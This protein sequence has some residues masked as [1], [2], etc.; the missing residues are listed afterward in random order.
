MQIFRIAPK[1]Y[2]E[3]YRGLG[4]S[5]T[6]GARWNRVGQPVMYFAQSAATA[7]LEMANYLPSPRLAPRNLHLGIYELP[8]S[9]PV[10]ELPDA[11]LPGDWKGFPYPA[12]T[13]AIGGDWLDQC[14]ELVLVVP[15]VAVPKG[16]EKILVVNPRHGDSSRIRLIDATSELYNQRSFSGI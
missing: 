7:L 3:D 11:S 12:S 4:A 15:S 10:F 5:Y 16:L 1:Q 6:D 13:Q 8:D 2:L 14:S 9:A